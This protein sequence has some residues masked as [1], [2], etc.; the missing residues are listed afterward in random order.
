VKIAGSE[1]EGRG[2]STRFSHGGEWVEKLA[3]QAKIMGEARMLRDEQPLTEEVSK[4]IVARFK[5]FLERTG[6]S[7]AW[8]ARSLGISP[9]TL[10]PVVAGNYAADAEPHLRAIDKWLESQLMKEAAPKPAGFVRIKV[11]DRI[12]GVARWVQQSGCIGVIHGPAGI[13]KTMTLKAIRSETPGCIF[14]SI[15]TAGQSKL[16]VYET[17]AQAVGLTGLK[18]T[19]FQIE[20]MLVEK[21]NESGRLIIVDEVHKLEGR[22]HDE[23]LHALRDLHDATGC[24][25]LWSGMTN[26]ANYIQ[27]GQTKWEPLDQLASRIGFWLNLTDAIEATDGG[28]G[29]YSEADIRKIIGTYKLRIT[30][31]GE[32]WLHALANTP[33][34]GALR[35]IDKLLRVVAH[36]YADKVITASLLQSA[37]IEQL[38]ARMADN[39][40][41]QMESWSERRAVA[42]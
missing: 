35:T 20:R 3:A 11:V 37:R 9:G 12:Y 24:P 33:R 28:K 22:R 39:Y 19:S 1:Y 42:G 6:K 27:Q 29:A 26:I 31:D 13:G 25:M 17:L 38:G 8:A 21:L 5:A 32:A 10:T 2:L 15:T 34:L 14:I 36:V 40:E 23:A 16:S 18:L 4:S 41:R 30:P 7:A